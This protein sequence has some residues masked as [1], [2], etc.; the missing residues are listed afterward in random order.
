MEIT[1]IADDVQMII[2][3]ILS[4]R[5]LMPYILFNAE[6]SWEYKDLFPDDRFDINP[7]DLEI[8]LDEEG[9]ASPPFAQDAE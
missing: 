3:D 6:A 9:K 2:R 8:G 1:S 4:D 7:F 5:H